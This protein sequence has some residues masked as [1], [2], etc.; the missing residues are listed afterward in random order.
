[1]HSHVKTRSC[2]HGV[3]ILQE[4]GRYTSTQNTVKCSK[5]TEW[6]LKTFSPLLVRPCRPCYHFSKHSVW[7][8]QIINPQRAEFRINHL[9][10][11]F[12]FGFIFFFSSSLSNYPGGAIDNSE[13][14]RARAG[15]VWQHVCAQQLQ[16]R[17][18]SEETRPLGRWEL[19][20]ERGAEITPSAISVCF[21]EGR[22]AEGELRSPQGVWARQRQ[23]KQCLLHAK[24]DPPHIWGTGSPLPLRFIN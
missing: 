9:P 24:Y 18:E 17:E 22:R 1:M 7:P 11:W 4:L 15:R 21:Q 10:G 19:C 3:S 23:E 12:C 5:C 14:G 20:L 8:N 6:R 16:A 13:R 2:F